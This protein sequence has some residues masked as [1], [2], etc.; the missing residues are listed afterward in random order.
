M[1]LRIRL[2]SHQ[3]H[4]T[5]LQYYAVRMH[6]IYSQTQNN[7]YTKMNLKHSEMGP[8]KQNPIQ[9]TVCAVH[10]VQLLHTMLHRTDLI[11]FP[12]ALQTITIAPTMSI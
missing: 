4:L 12:L 1:V 3:V 10:C 8:A 5:K 7:T 6:A 9:R 2:E 11:N